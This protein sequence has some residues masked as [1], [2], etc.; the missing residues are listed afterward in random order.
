M[1]LTFSKKERLHSKRGFA[2]L[3]SEGKYFNA[4]SLGIRYYF[5]PPSAL[6]ENPIMMSLGVAKR[7]F[8]RANKRNLLR[9][10]IREAYRIHRL[11]LFQS[12][13]EQNRNLV[14]FFIY[15]P[16]ETIEYSSIEKDM[17]RALGKLIALV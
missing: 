6:V 9:R 2:L 7:K 15:R 17:Q 5:D 3:F 8:K 16:N 11:P 1:R 13:S 4:G 10:R 12:L 14:V